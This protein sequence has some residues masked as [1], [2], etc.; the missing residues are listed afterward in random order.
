MSF[1]TGLQNVSLTIAIIAFSFPEEV[2]LKMAVIPGVYMIF[3]LP[4][5]G[6]VC[7]YFRRRDLPAE[8]GAAAA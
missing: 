1:E 4:L 7:W 3:V 5:A 6:L 2:Q 8:N